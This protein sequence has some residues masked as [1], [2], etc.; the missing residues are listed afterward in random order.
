MKHP[1]TYAHKLLEELSKERLENI[2]NFS[3]CAMVLLW[4]LG[5]EPEHDIDAVLT[6]NDM[7]KAGVIEKDCTVKWV[8]AIR[9]LTGRES[10]VEFINI[11]SLK[12]IKERTPVRYDYKGKWHW[13]GVERGIICFTPL[14][15]SQ[16]V[17]KGSPTTMRKITI[18]GV[19]K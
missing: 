10:T 12:G 11:K 9:F 15:Y 1:Q 17:E 16:C 19:S 18:K 4:C 7:I 13:V 5:I 3:C 14:E 6:V 8:E 2:Y